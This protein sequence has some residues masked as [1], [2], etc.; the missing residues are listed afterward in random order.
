M[1]DARSGQVEVPEGSIFWK[2]DPATS[3]SPHPR[4]TFVF[5]HA[6]VA[7][8]ELWDDQVQYLTVRGWDCLRY[9][10]FGFNQ[11]QP[12]EQFLQSS[13]KPPINHLEHLKRLLETVLPNQSQV[14]LVG[15]SMGG[16]L[17]LEFTTTY[18]ESVAGLV[19]AAGGIRGFDAP[20]QPEE[21]RL[22]EEK[23]NALESGQTDQAARLEVRFWG[24]G[25]LQKPG[26]LAKDVYDKLYRWCSDIAIREY[27]KEG[28]GALEQTEPDPPALSRLHEIK[29]PTAVAYGTYDETYTTQAMK[30]LASNVSNVTA[31]EFPAAHIINLE[32][33]DEFNDWLGGWSDKFFAA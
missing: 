15:L 5:L 23:E 2:Y 7:N 3:P 1:A 31:K 33:P 4:P 29:I 22:I 14:I 10:L 24:D 28:G 26:R 18:P 27:R 19:V 30:H 32:L 6:G 17:A 25:P 16:L 8:H 9:D 13:P 12:N 20:N 21:D 11:S